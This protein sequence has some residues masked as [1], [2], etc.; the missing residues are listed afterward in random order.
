MAAAAPQ[1]R[2]AQVMT[3]RAA[4]HH[5]DERVP[6][7]AMLDVVARIAGLHA[8]VMSSAELT[9][10]ARV[11]GLEPDDVSGALWSVRSVV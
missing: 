11:E 7:K 3:W 1:L 2:W 8:Q 10:A 4:R 9:L 5:L 6:A